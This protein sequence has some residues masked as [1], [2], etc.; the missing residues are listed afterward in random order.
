MSRLRRKCIRTVRRPVVLA[1]LCCGFFLSPAFRARGSQLTNVETVF[2]VVMENVSWSAIKGSAAAPYI[3]NTLLPL[4]A[5]CEQYYSPTRVA[6]SLTDYFWLEGAMSFGITG[7]PEP[8]NA[9]ISNP[10]HLVTLLET[11]G[12][13]WKGYFEGI[14]G[15]NCPL[16]SGGLYAAD[17]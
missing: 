6:S 8:A 4:A 10:N 13:P 12:I 17:H 5:H 15:T 3:N 16:A 1:V 7:S 9:R 11:A 2:L 14:S